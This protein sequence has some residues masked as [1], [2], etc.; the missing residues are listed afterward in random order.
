M[1]RFLAFDIETAKVVTDEST[2]LLAS[3]PLGIAC[4]VAQA[5]DMAQ[6]RVWH[7]IDAAGRPARQM[8]QA[9]SAAMVSELEQFVSRGYTIVT[10]NGAAFDFNVIAEE[11]ALTERTARLAAVHVDMIFQ[12]VCALGHYVSLQKAAEGMELKGKTEGMSGALAPKMWAEGRYQ[13]VIDYCTQDVRT[14]LAL[15]EAAERRKKLVWITQRGTPRSL[16]L[17]D[18]WLNVHDANLLPPPDTSWMSNP[19]DRKQLLSWIPPG[20][21]APP[22]G[23][24][25][26]LF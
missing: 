17:P 23:Q 19:P 13:E 5:S 20:I 10:W 12:A 14:T 2:D 16:A 9:E 22:A 11:S 8:S 15:A 26:R 24:S 18:G 6:P 7:G 25:G 3:R 21:L 1:T 4:A